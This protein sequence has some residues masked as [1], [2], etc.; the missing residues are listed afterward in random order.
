MTGQEIKLLHAFNAWATTRV[1]D[2]V[3]SLPHEDVMKD[4][5][6]SHASIH[7]TILHQAFAEQLWLDRWTGVPV[8]NPM[9]AADAPTIAALRKFWEQTGYDGAKFF[10]TLTDQKL[11]APLTYTNVAGQKTTLPLWQSVLHVVDHSTYHRG[12][13]VAL[14]RQLGHTPPSTGM[15]LFFREVAK[16]A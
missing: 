10:G 2:A 1:F 13:V 16:I 9:T 7:G 15:A 8:I 5:K 12:Q 11:Q 6:S 3:A 14:L 4:M